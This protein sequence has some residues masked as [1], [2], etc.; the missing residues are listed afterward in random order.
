MDNV[1]FSKQF[2]GLLHRGLIAAKQADDST[3]ETGLLGVSSEIS[4]LMLGQDWTKRPEMLGKIIIR[5]VQEMIA[6]KG[7]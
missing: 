7:I 6:D 1:D 4:S 2:E 5:T 3:C